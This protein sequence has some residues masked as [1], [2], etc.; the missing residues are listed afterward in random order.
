MQEKNNSQSTNVKNK[1][2]EAKS[3]LDTQKALKLKNHWGSWLLKIGQYLTRR[4][5]NQKGLIKD[6]VFLY[7][8]QTYCLGGRNDSCNRTLQR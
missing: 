2:D 7:F 4:S 5:R 1:L 8:F 3:I 6:L